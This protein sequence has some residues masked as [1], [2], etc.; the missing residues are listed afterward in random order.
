M[1]LKE[2]SNKDEWEGF[3]KLCTEKTFLQSWNWGEFQIKDGNKIWRFVIFNKEKFVGVALVIKFSAKRGTF[4]FVPH[5]PVVIEGLDAKDK[6]EVLELILI[7]LSDIAKEEKASFIRFSPNLT[8]T[9]KTRIFLL[10][11]DLSLR[12]HMAPGSHVGIGDYAIARRAFA[13]Y[14]ENH[15]I[16]NSAGGK[17]S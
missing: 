14:A 2:I 15:K 8:R 7:Q 4:L 5:G 1:E 17:K 16:F 13:E 3:L 12:Q 6:K 11:W 10:I 9:K